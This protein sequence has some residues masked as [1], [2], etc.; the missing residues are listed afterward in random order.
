MSLFNI[1]NN[2][3]LYRILLLIPVEKR[4]GI[5]NGSKKLYKKL[6]YF[7]ITKNLYS[8]L[9]L[10]INNIIKSYYR[11]MPEHSI[12]IISFDSMKTLSESIQKKFPNKSK[13]FL[14]LIEEIIFESLKL[15]KIFKIYSFDYD[16]ILMVILVIGLMNMRMTMMMMIKLRTLLNM[17][18]LRIIMKNYL[19]IIF[20]II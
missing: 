5:I 12:N 10:Y 20:M 16:F 15:N 6:E 8:K 11:K 7:Y 4:I 14:E 3:I 18:L 13:H 9:F 1:K 17:I 19:N 2:N